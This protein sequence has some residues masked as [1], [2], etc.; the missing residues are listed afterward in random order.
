[1]SELSVSSRDEGQYAV[2]DVAGDLDL[3]SAPA[4]RKKLTSLFAEGHRL[5]VI[6]LSQVPFLDSTGIGVLVGAQ[7]NVRRNDGNVRIVCSDPRVLRVFTITGLEQVFSIHDTVEQ[8][9]S[10]ED[11]PRQPA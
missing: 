2:V 6:D 7:W 1:M 4:L 5:I 9:L 8:A 10:A 11:G 3:I